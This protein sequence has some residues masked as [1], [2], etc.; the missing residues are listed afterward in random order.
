MGRAIRRVPKGWEH[1]CD[2]NGDYLPMMDVTYKDALADW[3]S[4]GAVPSEK[5]LPEWYRP[6]YESDPVCYQVYETVTEGTPVSPVFE[7]EDE[8]LT[9]LLGQ[10]HSE[11]ASREF[12]K[13]GWAPSMLIGGGRFAINID[14]YDM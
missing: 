6:A 14:T 1:P 8:L 5:P 3:Q 9:W 7:T 10:G 2:T 11:K 4:E 12:I 13:K